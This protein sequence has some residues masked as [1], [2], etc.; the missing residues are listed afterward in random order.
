MFLRDQREQ[1]LEHILTPFS[2]IE[3]EGR[4]CTREDIVKAQTID[5]VCI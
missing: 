4:T 2:E 3:L 1:R 5:I